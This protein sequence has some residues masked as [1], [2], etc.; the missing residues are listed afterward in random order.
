MAIFPSEEMRSIED[1][2]TSIFRG[3]A[4]LAKTKARR[5]PTA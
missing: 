4:F 2:I 5:K 3:V 1:P